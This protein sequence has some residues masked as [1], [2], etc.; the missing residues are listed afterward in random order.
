MATIAPIE[1][2]D[3]D[4]LCS[5]ISFLCG[6]DFL[7][8]L[9]VCRRWSGLRLK[10]AAW[11]SPQLCDAHAVSHADAFY[12]LFE[13]TSISGITC[14]AFG[15]V[16]AA[17]VHRLLELGVLEL[18]LPRPGEKSN[19]T[20]FRQCSVLDA[21]KPISRTSGFA[22]A[23][24]LASRGIVDR[25]SGLVRDSECDGVRI[26]ACAVMAAVLHGSTTA[27]VNAAVQDGLIPTLLAVARNENNRQHAAQVLTSMC[28]RGNDVHRR[29][30]VAGGALP[31]VVNAVQQELSSSA[32]IPW[33][34]DLVM[35]PQGAQVHRAM[36][37]HID[38]L[39]DQ[40]Q[41][42]SLLLQTAKRMD[43]EEAAAVAGPRAPTAAAVADPHTT[44]KAQC[45]T[46]AD[47]EPKQEHWSPAVRA[48][49][50]EVLKEHF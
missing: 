43:E 34:D 20:S 49:L 46:R 4:S 41:A 40:L 38:D 30:L 24:L 5:V 21:L 48:K 1:S 2:V 13:V 36:M 33:E 37:E 9:R 19:G 29:A 17:G 31:L 12:G 44:T 15:H 22:H 8:V 23:S 14:M 16:S 18:L 3:W 6:C 10:P 39:L 28:L 50:T 26:R 45:W 35:L 47:L 32:L 42:V 25:L 7:R 11:P 27:E